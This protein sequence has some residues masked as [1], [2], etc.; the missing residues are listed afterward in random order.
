M[1]APIKDMSDLLMDSSASLSFMIGVNLFMGHLPDDDQTGPVVCLIDSP[2]GAPD[3]HNI[4][5]LQVQILC[6]GM[7]GGYEDAYDTITEVL[8]ALH[9]RGNF[10]LNGSQYLLIWKTG[11]PFQ[12]G[13]DQLGRPLLSANLRIKRI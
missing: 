6:R 3:P 9:G 1:S 2:G 10:Q 12:L 5:N 7:K 4:D 8:N 11:G 13:N